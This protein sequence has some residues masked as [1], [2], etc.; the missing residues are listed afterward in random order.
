M[1]NALVEH[2][3]RAKYDRS[4]WYRISKSHT[5]TSARILGPFLTHFSTIVTHPS[6]H[7]CALPYFMHLTFLKPSGELYYSCFALWFSSSPFPHFHLQCLFLGEFLPNGVWAVI[8]HVPLSV[9]KTRWQ[10]P[11]GSSHCA[12]WTTNTCAYI[13]AGSGER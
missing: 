1:L 11:W 7:T 4:L 6:R 2:L 9:T 8:C 10:R 13:M 12:T 5:P 3:K